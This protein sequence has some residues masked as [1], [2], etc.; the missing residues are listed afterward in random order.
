MPGKRGVERP[1]PSPPPPPP[2]TVAARASNLRYR[3]NFA[4]YFKERP[5]RLRRTGLLFGLGLA[6]ACWVSAQTRQPAVTGKTT[7]T[8]RETTTVVRV[9]P[10][11]AVMPSESAPQPVGYESDIYCFGYLGDLNETFPLEVQSAENVQSQVDYM[12][13]DLLYVTGGFDRGLRIG[14]SYWL[15]TAEQEIFHPVNGR[16]MGRLYQYRG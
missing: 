7:V 6:L 2:L 10:S 1:R 3:A 13:G 12:T 14:D 9:E 15:I 4:I 5:M 8:N 11:A 16:S